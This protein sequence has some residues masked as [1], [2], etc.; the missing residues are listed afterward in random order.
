M[1]DTRRTLIWLALWLHLTLSG[2]EQRLL[3]FTVYCPDGQPPTDWHCL[4]ERGKPVP[5]TF[6]RLERSPPYFTRIVDRLVLY[7][8][9]A[10]ASASMELTPVKE[11]FMPDHE[12]SWLLV[13][14]P[15]WREDGRK[16]W[17]IFP[18]EDSERGFPWETLRILNATSVTLA[19][20]VGE[21]NTVI[22]PGVTRPFSLRSLEGDG[23]LP[24][25][26]AVRLQDGYSVAY[27]NRIPFGEDFRSLLILMPPTRRDSI[28]IRTRLLEE[29][30]EQKER[31]S[32]RE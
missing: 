2:Q 23:R 27:A 19:G 22:P 21:E 30:R 26:F 7:R 5:L 31:E 1:A 17:Q 16:D 20:V 24:L 32:V 10:L 12:H 6:R 3:R 9:V 28:R 11:I 14:L 13:L 15:H 4:D 8:E 25:G 29:Q 18:L